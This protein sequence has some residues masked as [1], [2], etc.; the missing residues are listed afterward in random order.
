MFGTDG[1]RGFPYKEPLTKKTLYKIG[2]SFAE[3]F[4]RKENISNIFIAEDTRSSSKYIKNNIIKGINSAGV[5]AIK[6]NILPTASLSFF[7]RKYPE[8]AGIMITA[9]HNDYRYNVD[10]NDNYTVTDGLVIAIDKEDQR[11]NRFNKGDKVDCMIQDI[12]L[13][14]KKI[15]LSIKMLELEQN[16]EAIKK[17]G[18]VDSGKSLPFAGLTKALKKKQDKKEEK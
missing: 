7:T 15:S 1:I 3:Y 6:L 2:Y 13:S 16:K 9:S 14:K 11:T 10:V 8:S 5:V 4:K 12:E 18:S 17:Y